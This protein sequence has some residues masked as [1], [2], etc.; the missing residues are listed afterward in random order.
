MNTFPSAAELRARSILAGIPD[1]LMWEDVRTKNSTLY[2][3]EILPV[4]FA[5]KAIGRTRV[6]AVGETVL[7][8]LLNISEIPDFDACV[9]SG[10]L[11][12]LAIHEPS[13]APNVVVKLF[14]TFQQQSIVFGLMSDFRFMF[15]SATGEILK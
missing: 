11:A 5:L 6:P 1:Q 14:K 12:L 13:Q 15:M 4:L 8:T 3:K 2:R 10:L 7:K 9:I